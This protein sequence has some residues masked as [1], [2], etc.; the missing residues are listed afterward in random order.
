[1]IAAQ[2][3]DPDAELPIAPR[4]CAASCA[5]ATACCSALDA[6]G[7]GVAAWRL[8][9]GRARKEDAGERGGR[10]RLRSRSPA[11]PSSAASRS[12][13]CTPTTTR[14]LDGA[15]AAL[16][17]A[18]EVGDDAVAAAPLVA[19]AHRQL[20]HGADAARR[21]DRGRCP[22][23]D[24]LLRAP[25]VL[26]HDHLDGGLRPATVV[27]L[28]E[29]SGYAGLPTTDPDELGRWFATDA[30][31][32]RPRALPR[33]LRPHRRGDA[34]QGRA[35]A[36]G[37]RVRGGPRARRR[38]LRRGPLRAR[39]AHRAAASTSRRSSSR[40]SPASRPAPPRPPRPAGRSSCARCSP[41]CAPRPGP[42]R[43]PSS[44]SRSATRACAGSTSRA[45]RPATR[46]TQHLD[47]FQLV[48]RENFHATLHAGEAFG[49]PS[50]WEAL[51]WCN[52][53]RLGHGVRIVDDIDVGAG[54]RRSPR[55]ARRLRPRPPRPP[56]D[57]PDVQRPHRRG[58]R[59]SPSTRS[60][61]CGACASA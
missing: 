57:V 48:Q 1:M 19:G 6:L 21:Y 4:S 40:C 47:A 32:S 61:C 53:E 26:L 56:R 49:L 33:G 52:A 20:S 13:S 35:R 27:E 36:R 39:A 2:G 29:E 24:Q 16:R 31:R 14:R 8:G 44:P 3:G 50:I 17:G 28:A 12:S 18:I 45:P 11:T 37:A 5:S 15:L 42:A 22:P 60:S 43:S 38:R 55:P 58:R 7:V 41:R 59:R 9:A 34:E 46:P 51:Q 30:P 23:R 54:R 10:R 25:K